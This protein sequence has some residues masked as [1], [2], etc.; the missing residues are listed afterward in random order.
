MA[1]HLV[2]LPLG[3][4]VA[5]RSTHCLHSRSLVAALLKIKKKTSEEVFFYLAPEVGLEPTTP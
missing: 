1:V 5:V 3:Y 2:G 4:E